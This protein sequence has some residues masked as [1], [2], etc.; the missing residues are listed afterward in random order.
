MK[1]RTKTGSTTAAA[2]ALLMMGS[3]GTQA[4][5][6]DFSLPD[7][8]PLVVKKVDP[9]DYDHLAG[10]WWCHFLKYHNR[11][12]RGYYSVW[13]FD[14]KNK[15][16]HVLWSPVHK[17]EVSHYDW[18]GKRLDTWVG[19]HYENIAYKTQI[20]VGGDLVMEDSRLRWKGWWCSPQAGIRWP[21]DGL[22]FLDYGRYPWLADLAEDG[23]QIAKYESQGRRR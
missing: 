15:M 8:D 7:K 3:G 22:Q 13:T 23:R 20:R 16:V 21:E 6:F 5:E 1:I 4:E 11:V 2:V 17:G 12:E 18:N 19:D 14:S 9:A 10:T